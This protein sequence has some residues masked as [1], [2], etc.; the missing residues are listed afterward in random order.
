MRRIHFIAAFFLIL[1][2]LAPGASAKDINVSFMVPL[3][4]GTAFYGKSMREIG[5]GVVND[6]NKEGIKGFEKIN[7]TVYDDGSDPAV[8]ARAIERAVSQ[9]ANFIW[10]GVSSSVEEMMVTKANELK[11]PTS[12]TNEHTDRAIPCS[13]KYAI[14]PT[15]STI[16]IGGICAKYFKERGV[17][18]YAIIGADYVYPRTWD[19]ALTMFLKGTGIKK[20]YENFHSL[21]KVDYSADIAKLKELKP[22][23]VVRPFG[24]AGEYVIVKQMKD[25][26]YW[27]RVFIVGPE[28]G[29]YHVELDQLGEN[30]LLGVTSVTT[31]NPENPRWI[32]FAKT[33]KERFGVWPTW[34]S[35]GMHDT[36]WVFK[37]AV[38]K[39]GTL[40]PDVLAKALREVSYN[41]VMAYPCGPFQDFGYVRKGSLNLLEYVKGSPPWTD[42]I[43]ITQKIVSSMEGAPQCYEK[44]EEMLKKAE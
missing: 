24:G 33:H 18:T 41:G 5:Q 17:K 2:L 9:G 40:S 43:G 4:G 6:I 11:I 26:G 19:K 32:Q 13:N 12:L 15:M 34:L 16:E 3:T 31:Q 42:K 37:K 35:H 30:Y 23:A 39:A 25:E 10:G 38:E 1:C 21:S 36:L 44:I 20:V 28:M 27:P 14:T 29:G 8:V 7:V 22:D